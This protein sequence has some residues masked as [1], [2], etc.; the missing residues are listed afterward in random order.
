MYFKIHSD[1]FKRFPDVHIGVLVA[2]E[3]DNK[4][5]SE[6]ILNAIEEKSEEIK[7]EFNMK[8]VSEHAK[9]DVWRKAYSSFGAKPKKYTCSVE[10]I[11]RMILEGV[12]LRHINKAVDIYNYV[13]IK[14]MIPVGGDDIEKIDG[15][16]TLRYASGS[17][18]FTELNC[19][20][21]KRPKEG[22]IVYADDTEVL[23]RRWNWRECEKSKMTEDTKNIVLVA[24]A[25]PPTSKEDIENILKELSELIQ[26]YCGGNIKTDI[27]SSSNPEVEI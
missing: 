6:D 18:A 26:K 5:V 19:G 12:K 10:N 22:E 3:I 13:S 27:L 17:E 16:I 24:E 23:C 15:N 25:L 8:S 9:I 11:Y 1:I 4:G 21:S 20:E 7:K 14:H 2:R